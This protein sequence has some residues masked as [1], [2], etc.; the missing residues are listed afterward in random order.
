MERKK[1]EYVKSHAK[2]TNRESFRGY[3]H[4]VDPPLEYTIHTVREVG[5]RGAVGIILREPA[6]SSSS[7]NGVIEERYKLI[8]AAVNAYQE[9]E[10]LAKPGDKH[11]P[12]QSGS[13]GYR[14]SASDDISF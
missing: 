5:T 9:K 13:L 7:L 4:K 6:F 10:A 8:V 2:Q 11:F 1:W 3:D 14:G 12:D